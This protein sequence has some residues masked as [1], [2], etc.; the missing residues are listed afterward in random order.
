MMFRPPKVVALA[1]LATLAAFALF[2]G[3]GPK[4]ELVPVL[5]TPSATPKPSSA[6]APSPLPSGLPAVAVMPPPGVRG[7]TKART[8]ADEKQAR[9]VSKAQPPGAGALAEAI[10]RTGAACDLKPASDLFTAT[11]GDG[12]AHREFAWKAS[13]GRCY[14]VLSARDAKVL[15]MVLLVRDAKGDFAA[16]GPEGALPA[17][18]KLCFE[19]ADDATLLV[20]VGTGKGAFAVQVWQ[21]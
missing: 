9:C 1:A 14:R 11:L 8:K 3:C 10:K 17:D 19:S 4:V 5:P 15:D 6:A 7:S 21:E 20:S 16:Q 18:G 12:D 13:A 2:A